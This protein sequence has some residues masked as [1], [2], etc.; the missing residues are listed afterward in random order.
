MRLKAD[1][2]EHHT[3]RQREIDIVFG[4]CPEKSFD[5]GLELGAGDGF[6]SGLLSRYV[7]ELLV[8]D[9]YPD[10]VNLPARPGIS[11]QVLDAEGVGDA[12]EASSFDLVFSSN[13]LEHLPD[14][15]RAL[16][17]INHVMAA[18]GLAVHVLPSAFWKLSQLGLF[19]PNVVLSRLDHYGRGNLPRPLRRLL[20]NGAQA[21]GP[22]RHNN[23]KVEGAHLDWVHR[24]LVPPVH[25]AVGGNWKESLRFRRQQ[26]HDAFTQS[27]FC[28][29]AEIAG[30]AASGYGFGL[31]W[32][33]RQCEQ[34][35]W[36]GEYAYVMVK[37]GHTSPRAR[38]FTK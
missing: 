11:L 7:R 33:R 16:A 25:G 21:T 3:L 32:A 31:D 13:L 28:I 36:V 14:L 12:F 10:I 18:D 26:W 19:Y 35:G 9:Y 4:H 30:P 15:P 5:R 8:T 22:A 34:A 37:K 27:G 24:L 38:H 29:V 20:R 1:W 6:I 23:P 17:G 2:K